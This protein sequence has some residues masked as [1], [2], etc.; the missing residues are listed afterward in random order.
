MAC[1]VSLGVNNNT[2]DDNTSIVCID[3]IMLVVSVQY[4][5][6]DFDN[7]FKVSYSLVVI[8]CCMSV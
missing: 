3:L 8:V 7:I 2:N 6:P 4:L 1:K 5:Y